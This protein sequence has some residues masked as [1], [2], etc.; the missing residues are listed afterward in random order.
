MTIEQTALLALLAG[1]MLAFAFD[2]WRVEV[3]AVAGLSLAV[4]L[5]LI[6]AGSVFS[7]FADPAVIT[8]VELL[9]IAQALG[10]SPLA[11]ITAR[12][13][14]AFQAGESGTIALLCAAAA[15]ASA[16]I[17]NVGALALMLPVVATV[18]DSRG[19]PP[20]RVLMPVSF[21]TL[22][23]GLCS[24]IGTPAN[25]VVSRALAEAEGTGLGFFT[26]AIVGVPLSILGILWLAGVG[27]RLLAP[28][29]RRPLEGED[30]PIDRFLTEVR[31]PPS[32]ALIGKA[33]TEV[34]G[35][36]R[37]AIHGVFRGPARLFG[38]KEQ[39]ILAAGD[40]LLISSRVAEI[41]AFL[42]QHALMPAVADA[43]QP[44]PADRVWREVVVMPQSAIIGSALGAIA[45]FA[46][47]DVQVVGI[48][49]Q[50]DRIEGRLGDVAPAIGDILLIRGRAED[51]AAAIA[52]TDCAPLAARPLLFASAETL[53]PLGAFVGA[54]GLA[55]SG[56]APPELAFGLAIAFLLVTRALDLGAALRAINWPVIV[57]LAAMLP[58]GQALQTTGTADLLARNALLAVG[59]QPMVIVL[60]ATLL[61]AIVVTPF[62]NNVTTAIILAPIAIS[63]GA[64]AGVPLDLMLVAVAV[65]A[66]T[67]FMTPFGHHNNTLVMSLGGYSFSDFPKVGAALTLIVLVAAPIILAAMG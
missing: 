43:A 49:P 26:L 33:V 51:I 63:V 3:V 7:G 40:I 44:L 30:Y 55:S 2:R 11:N 41:R 28:V 46:E 47:R 9:V 45:A 58:I 27:H 20:R 15:L 19:I 21:A 52:D 1:L 32:S 10:R 14:A 34:E 24:L 18:C 16:F 42:T 36:N 37:L 6:P 60:A 54:V 17:N 25:L 22:L 29:G 61:V 64:Q 56:V 57:M 66:S 8:V 4:L 50:R 67:D 5:G 38:R 13:I 48:S 62:L 35:A 65:G 53:M 31:L 12:R 59:D 23:G 39:Q